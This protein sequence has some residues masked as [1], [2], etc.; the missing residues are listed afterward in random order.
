M[1][2]FFLPDSC[3]TPPSVSVAGDL[4]RHLRDS[5]RTRVG[6]TL[7]I[8][9]G[10]TRRYRITVTAITK[11]G[12]TGHIS[13]SLSRPAGTTP[14]L[15]LGQA[16]LKGDKMDW[17]IQ[18]ATELGVSRIVPLLCRHSLVQPK[19]GRIDQQLAR[20]QRIALEAAQQSEQWSVPTIDLPR[21]LATFCSAS[22]HD[23]RLMLAERRETGARMN[24]LPLPTAPES[25]VVVVI[26]PEGG[27]TQDE[28][29][30]AE[31]AG[32]LPVTL[33]PTVL[34]AETAA[35]TAVGILQHRLG[36]LG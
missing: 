19:A 14:S 16:L 22:T 18:K 27:W 8:G 20:W 7:M 26:G 12:L 25:S 23:L 5:L 21:P 1:P 3:I 9:D 10:R 11:Q 6:E 34:R 31:Q 33:G 36:A 15:T 4:L 24:D 30:E 29:A 28:A 13:E 2:V 17:V 32:F 35:V